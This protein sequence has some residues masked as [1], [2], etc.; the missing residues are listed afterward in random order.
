[1]LQLKSSIKQ[2]S[3]NDGMPIKKYSS[4]PIK[5]V[6]KTPV[7][8][9]EESEGQDLAL[10]HRHE[11][12]VGQMVG[13][14]SF[15]EVY[16]IASFECQQKD[17]K[18]IGLMNSKSSSPTTTSMEPSRR[19]KRRAVIAEHDKNTRDQVKGM[20]LQSR[21]VIKQL[22]K[23]LLADPKLFRRAVRDMETECKLMSKLE[24][25]HI[26]RLRATAFGGSKALLDGGKHDSYFLVLDRLF[27]TLDDR[28]ERWNQEKIQIGPSYYLDSATNDIKISLKANFALQVAS[29]LQYLHE[30]SIIFRD[31]KPQNIGFKEVNP[32][33]PEKDVL[34]LFDFGLAREL[35][36]PEKANEQGLFRMSMVGT[37]R[38]MSP[39]VVV[40][41]TYDCR[42]DTYSWA[43][44]F[45]ELLSQ[46]RP[47]DGIQRNEHKEFICVQG[48]RPKLYSYYG[49][50]PELERMIRFA[51]AQDV[52]KRL[53]MK[54]VCETLQDYLAGTIH[55]NAVRP[56]PS[57]QP[58]AIFD[59]SI[60]S[61]LSYN[62]QQTERTVDTA[63]SCTTDDD[64][65]E[66]D[67]PT[68]KDITEADAVVAE[69]RAE[70]PK[71][72]AITSATST[73]LGEQSN[74]DLHSPR[75][76]RPSVCSRCFSLF[77][78]KRFRFFRTSSAS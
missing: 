7:A 61:L 25:P 36:D 70:I 75:R 67:K 65:D 30:H 60:S 31:L 8:S 64:D 63:G 16:E 77:S 1:M 27:E 2:Q 6:L 22:H 17:N 57:P 15:S 78:F 9:A 72:I 44:C 20:S 56:L 74:Y 48:K 19:R 10:F 68:S 18:K 11:I 69:S 66:H 40:S 21:Y 46:S 3:S 54:E 41:K 12:K 38:Y 71:A 76:R 59:D 58:Q 37:R 62:T 5:D 23:K 53:S 4:L 47:Y 55:E 52:S 14:G 34:A 26:A 43:L 50:P 28:I 33:H 45:Y 35:P 29:A 39:E 51:W 49:L 32:D 24:H 42:A 73:E 13:S